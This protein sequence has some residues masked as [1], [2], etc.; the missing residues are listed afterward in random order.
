MR[1]PIV[2]EIIKVMLNIE[3]KLSMIFH[4]VHRITTNATE[5]AMPKQEEIYIDYY[6]HGYKVLT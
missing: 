4:E 1:M 5:I 2:T 3:Y 6:N